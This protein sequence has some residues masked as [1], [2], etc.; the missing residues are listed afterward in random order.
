MLQMQRMLL[1]SARQ[2]DG[3]S[4]PV[5]PA[6]GFTMVELLVTVTVIAILAT[7]AAP[8]FR[9]LLLDNQ[10]TRSANELVQAMYAARSEAVKR[11]ENIRVRSEQ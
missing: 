5:A 7:I 8:Y 3:R 9:E 1:P 6:G 10:L 2:I 11:T 4:T